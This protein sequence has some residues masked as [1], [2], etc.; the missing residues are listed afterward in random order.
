MITAGVILM[1]VLIALVLGK[2]GVGLAPAS[3]IYL[4]IVI[5]GGVTTK[6]KGDFVSRG[7][8]ISFLTGP[9]GLLVLLLASSRKKPAA[10][11]DWREFSKDGRRRE[12]PEDT[13]DW[14]ENGWVALVGLAS[15]VLAS[16]FI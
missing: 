2:T 16:I 12:K 10:A 9:F 11:D 6:L 4:L 15:F 13:G 8:A 7:F 1:A 14:P 3:T 5:A